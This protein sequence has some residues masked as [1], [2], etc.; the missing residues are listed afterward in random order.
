MECNRSILRSTDVAQD[1]DSEK[2]SKCAARVK[3]GTGT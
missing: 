1:A 3:P 2:F